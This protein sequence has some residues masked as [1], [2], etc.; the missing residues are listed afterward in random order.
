MSQKP[1]SRKAKRK[2]VAVPTVDPEVIQRHIAAYFYAL[3]G[4]CQCEA[5]Q[6]LRPSAQEILK[7][8]KKSKPGVMEGG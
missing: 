8:L 3:Y 5:C 4:D 7:R 2:T 6:L 1:K